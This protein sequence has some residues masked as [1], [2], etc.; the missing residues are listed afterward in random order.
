MGHP[1]WANRGHVH[2][3]AGPWHF[4]QPRYVFRWN[5]TGVVQGFHPMTE[6]NVVAS[7]YVKELNKFRLHHLPRSS[8]AA[9]GHAFHPF[10]NIHS[11]GVQR[12]VRGE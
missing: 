10:S 4:F 1:T 6:N 3:A 5:I 12:E 9:M 8:A 7:L 11:Y 2:V